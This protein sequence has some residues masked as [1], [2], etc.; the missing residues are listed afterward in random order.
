MSPEEFVR[1]NTVLAAPPLVPEIR[2]HLA[3][4]VT[5]LWEATEAELQRLHLPPPYWAFAWPGGQALARDERQRVFVAV[6]QTLALRREA[7]VAETLREVACVQPDGVLGGTAHLV[8]AGL[9]PRHVER[10]DRLGP[11]AD[12]LRIGLE[13]R[14][15]VEA[16]RDQRGPQLVQRLA[17]RPGRCDERLRP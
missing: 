4:E 13:H 2:L 6:G 14:V 12:G 17:E 15:D 11:Q 10:L 8:G 1:G 5:P 9:E 3:T 16:G 7:V